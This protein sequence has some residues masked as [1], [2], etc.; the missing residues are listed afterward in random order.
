[1]GC[2]VWT[3]CSLPFFT[4]RWYFSSSLSVSAEQWRSFQQRLQRELYINGSAGARAAREARASTRDSIS[5]HIIT[6]TPRLRVLS[7][8]PTHS[9]QTPFKHR[10]T[11]RRK[12][13]EDGAEEGAR[14]SVFGLFFCHPVFYY[15]MYGRFRGHGARETASHLYRGKRRTQNIFTREKSLLLFTLGFSRGKYSETVLK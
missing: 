9:P 6:S 15:G 4:C 8:T 10:L 7:V 12:R 13:G 14:F 3:D 5:V 2:N 1:M 11:S